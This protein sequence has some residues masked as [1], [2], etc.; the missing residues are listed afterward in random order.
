MRTAI[1]LAGILLTDT[2]VQDTEDSGKAYSVLAFF[3][4]LFLI[5]DVA[6]FLHTV[7]P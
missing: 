3:L 4:V 2:E 5:M 1:L 7:T 6:E